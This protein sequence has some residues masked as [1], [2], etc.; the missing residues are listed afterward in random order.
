[1]ALGGRAS[2]QVVLAFPSFMFTFFSC[3]SFIFFAVWLD[4]SVE[5]MQYLSVHL[6]FSVVNAITALLCLMDFPYLMFDTSQ[7]SKV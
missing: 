6:Y 7:S 5:R 4:L 2:E 3:F 1:M